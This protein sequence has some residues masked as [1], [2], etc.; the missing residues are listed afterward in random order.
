VLPQRAQYPA[1]SAPEHPTMEDDRDCVF[2][3]RGLAGRER[4]TDGACGGGGGCGGVPGEL[5]VH[6]VLICCNSPFPLLYFNKEQCIEYSVVLT[7]VSCLIVCCYHYY[8]DK[9]GQN[10]FVRNGYFIQ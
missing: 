8:F 5:C 1:A 9:S 2:G 6:D 7:E 10:V 3:L 4:G